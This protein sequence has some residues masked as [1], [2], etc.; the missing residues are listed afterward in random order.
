MDTI[1]KKSL[2]VESRVLPPEITALYAL[3]EQ[4]SIGI[5]VM[6]TLGAGKLISPE[7]TPFSKPMCVAQCTHY[8]LTRPAVFSALLGCQSCEQVREAVSYLNASDADKD[9]T[10]F[11]NELSSDFRGQCVYCNHCLPCPSVIDVAAVNRYLDIAKLDRDIA[12]SIHNGY[13]LYGFTLNL[14]FIFR[15]FSIETAIIFRRQSAPTTRV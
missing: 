14:S 3:C 2:D 6:K 10:Q 12:V 8:A 4:R 11:L 13:K 1:D 7:H 9:Y 5:S 15:P